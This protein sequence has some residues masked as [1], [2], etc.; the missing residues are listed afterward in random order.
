MVI[1]QKLWGEGYLLTVTNFFIKKKKKKPKKLPL[2]RLL[3]CSETFY[4]SQQPCGGTETL[5]LSQT[6]LFF[7]KCEAAVWGSTAA[8]EGVCL[9]GQG[10][11][12]GSGSYCSFPEGLLRCVPG[13]LR[14]ECP[15]PLGLF[16]GS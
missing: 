5:S 11:S 16:S 3:R 14:D 6:E 9:S 8:D 12:V 7:C 2:R 15:S 4:G 10:L 1:Q 13:I